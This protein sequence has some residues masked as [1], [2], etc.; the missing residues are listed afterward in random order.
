MGTSTSQGAAGSEGLV[1]L[2]LFA[3]RR[4]AYRM[5]N[6]EGTCVLF[7]CF[8]YDP[9]IFSVL[10]RCFQGQIRFFQFVS[11]PLDSFVHFFA[12]SSL[13]VEYSFPVRAIER[14]NAL[15]FCRYIAAV[16]ELELHAKFLCH[17]LTEER[18]VFPT[19]F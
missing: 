6:T 15:F 17:I 1:N 12:Y 2:G 11:L 8:F 16:T 14:Q 18:T 4:A 13:L 10:G 19:F 7:C 3:D 5:L 9:F